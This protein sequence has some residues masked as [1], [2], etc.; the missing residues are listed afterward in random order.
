M[1]C[2]V[3]M[4]F[5]SF[6]VFPF[7]LGFDKDEGSMSI[8]DCAFFCVQYVVIL[9]TGIVVSCFNDRVVYTIGGADEANI[10]TLLFIQSAKRSFFHCTHEH[11]LSFI[12][13]LFLQLEPSRSAPFCPVASRGGAPIA[14]TF[15]G[16]PTRRG[17]TKAASIT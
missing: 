6:C 8:V 14:R 7:F 15:H 13:L 2:S 10:Y 1:I 16:G 3:A 9:T 5:V 12:S 4:V 11:S 17:P